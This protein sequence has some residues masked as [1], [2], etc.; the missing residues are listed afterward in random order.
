MPGA[1]SHQRMLFR[2]YFRNREPDA[3]AFVEFTKYS[4]IRNRISVLP[5]ND[6]KNPAM[7]FILTRPDCKLAASRRRYTHSIPL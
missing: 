3:S 5:S 1:C 4:P 6:A 2:C 7:A